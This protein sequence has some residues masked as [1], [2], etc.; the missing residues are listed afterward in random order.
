MSR[1]EQET[2]AAAGLAVDQRQHDEDDEA[3]ERVGER[4][5]PPV[6]TLAQRGRRAGGAFRE[7]FALAGD[8]EVRTDRSVQAA[9]PGA[10]CAP[11]SS[12]AI[13]SVTSAPTVRW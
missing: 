5:R 12:C 7:A 8:T 13:D 1:D 2:T 9:R 10:S 11:A 4:E 6:E 3:A